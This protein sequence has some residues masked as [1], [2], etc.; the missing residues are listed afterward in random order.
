MEKF[1][2]VVVVTSILLFNLMLTMFTISTI[3]GWFIVPMGAPVIGWVQ[4]YGI[5][6]IMTYIAARQTPS[7]SEAIVKKLTLGQKI[8]KSVGI[9]IGVLLL[10]WIATLF[11]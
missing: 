1:L 8:G 3:W 9:N 11:M 2:S 7:F 5:A 4:A 10:G 6:L